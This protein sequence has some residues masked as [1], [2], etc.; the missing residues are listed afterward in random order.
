MSILGSPKIST[1]PSP[2]AVALVALCVVMAKK[3][4]CGARKHNEEIRR[5]PD[6]LGLGDT[7]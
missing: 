1:Q 4:F 2:L 7:L 3:N 6:S 5:M